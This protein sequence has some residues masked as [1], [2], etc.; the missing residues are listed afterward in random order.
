MFNIKSNKGLDNQVTGPSVPEGVFFF[1]RSWI[2]VQSGTAAA[3]TGAFM[4]ELSNGHLPA[5]CL[6]YSPQDKTT[7]EGN[8]GF[9]V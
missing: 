2:T 8:M 9:V 7:A 4:L 1:G 5:L 3:I 6:F